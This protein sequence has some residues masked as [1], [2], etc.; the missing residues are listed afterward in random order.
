[1][2]LVQSEEGEGREGMG[3]VMQGLGGQGR[4][5]AFTPG[6]WEH[7]RAV[8]RGALWL[9]G[10]DRLWGRGQEMAAL[11]PVGDDGA[12]PGGGGRRGRKWEE[13]G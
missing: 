9:Q 7:W 4:T 5:W 10:E 2:W 12:G 1:M 11:V 8:G 13:L 6:R 3:Q